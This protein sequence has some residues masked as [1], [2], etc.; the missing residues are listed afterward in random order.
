MSCSR[1]TV[2]WALTLAC[3]SASAC[4]AHKTSRPPPTLAPQP[5][6]AP[7][8][9]STSPEPVASALLPAPRC[10]TSASLPTCVAAGA[11][12]SRKIVMGLLDVAR[13]ASRQPNAQGAPHSVT[14]PEAQ[15]ATQTLS[16][17]CANPSDLEVAYALFRLYFDGRHWEEAAAL[18]ERIALDAPANEYSVHLA[19]LTLE[20]YNALG[21]VKKKPE[22]NEQL[23]ESLERFI[24]VICDPKLESS[25]V[26]QC[27]ELRKIKFEIE[28]PRPRG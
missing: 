23:V 24:A 18:G 14:P 13:Q 6:T 26:E 27:G 5:G 20:A 3:V 9:L 21:T 22:C 15:T 11:P 19:L 2:V 1:T 7:A 4:V 25:R 28:H 16:Y 12:P 8:L 17:W 10:L